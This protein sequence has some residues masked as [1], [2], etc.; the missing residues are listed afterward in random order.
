[1]VRNAVA[2]APTE[3][4]VEI[5]ANPIGPQLHAPA[6]APIIEPKTPPPIFCFDFLSILI[7]NMFIG[8]TSADNADMV[9]IRTNQNSVPDGIWLTTYGSKKMYSDKINNPTN[10]VEKIT[11]D[12][13]RYLRFENTR[14]IADVI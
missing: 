3:P 7:R 1:M 11:M 12:K 9:T 2:V 8:N 14:R 13:I 4:N 10:I 5:T 6:A